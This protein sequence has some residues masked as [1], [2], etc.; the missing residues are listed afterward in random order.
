MEIYFH[1]QVQKSKG[2]EDTAAPRLK[3]KTTFPPFAFGEMLVTINNCSS[4]IQSQLKV[5]DT[6]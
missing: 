6:T 4:L 3:K 1:A 5:K 2:R